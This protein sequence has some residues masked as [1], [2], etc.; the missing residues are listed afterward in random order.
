MKTLYESNPN[1]VWDWERGQIID[2]RTGEVV[3][4]IYVNYVPL[5]EDKY[6]NPRRFSEIVTPA[7]ILHP[8][9]LPRD[10]LE[11]LNDVI[12]IFLY[13]K[14][15]ITIPCSAYTIENTIRKYLK[16]LTPSEVPDRASIVALIYIALEENKVSVDVAELARAAEVSYHNVKSSIFRLKTSLNKFYTSFNEKVRKTIEMLCMK[17][18]LPPEVLRD[19]VEIFEEYS[20]KRS[21]NRY[22]PRSIAK[23]TVYIAMRRHGLSLKQVFRKKSHRF[24]EIIK[25]VCMYASCGDV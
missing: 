21:T 13:L 9:H 24:K 23:A 8:L 19:A 7:D 22:T 12:S 25:H 10:S 14:S 5:S 15:V 16:N 11:V 4:T 3:D 1:L 6:G 17:Y 18:H 2:S 20:R